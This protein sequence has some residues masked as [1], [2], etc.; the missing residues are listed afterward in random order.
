MTCSASETW[1]LVH[2]TAPGF[3][4]D[5]HIETGIYSIKFNIFSWTS[6]FSSE[7]CIYH[8]HYAQWLCY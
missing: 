7:E 2:I 3:P 1:D 8:V 5:V 6:Y 4:V